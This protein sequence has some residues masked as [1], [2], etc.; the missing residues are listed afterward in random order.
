MHLHLSLAVCEAS[1][2]NA[3]TFVPLAV[4]TASIVNALTFVP[5]EIN[6]ASIVN[7]LTFVPLAVYAAM[8]FIDPRVALLSFINAVISTEAR[9]WFHKAVTAIIQQVM[10]TK[11][12]G[13]T[14]G[15]AAVR[16]IEFNS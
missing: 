14:N 9:S 16:V 13:R 1:I 5:L 3:L 6:A 2:V 8:V 4:Y 10:T 7:A 11:G 15:T 12:Q